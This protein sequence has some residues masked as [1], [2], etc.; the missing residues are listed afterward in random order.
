MF[1]LTF[2]LNE[3]QDNVLAPEYLQYKAIVKHIL[4][5]YNIALILSC[6]ELRHMQNV[7]YLVFDVIII[8]IA[9]QFATWWDAKKMHKHS[10]VYLRGIT[11][12][13]RL[14]NSSPY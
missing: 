5:K 9:Y 8:D 7:F 4:L 3:Y 12:T 11:N 10:F 6:K 2:E 13:N 14:Q 1:I